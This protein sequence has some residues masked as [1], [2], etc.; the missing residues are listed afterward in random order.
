VARPRDGLE[1]S[2]AFALAASA[3]LAAACAFPFLSMKAGGLENAMTLPESALE[4][5]RNGRELLALLVLAF[6]MLVPALLLGALLALLVPLVRGRSAP[7]LVPAGRLVFALGPWSMVEVFV[8]GV[9]VSLVKLGA[10]AT[11]VLGISFWS[12][13]AFAVC[14]IAALSSL[15]RAY[16]WDAIEGA[17]GG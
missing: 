12:Y 16:L 4:L 15:D 14:L 8:I 17:S 3:L 7:W 5:Y 1:R 13:A 10:M 6:I 2:L 11:I 9:I